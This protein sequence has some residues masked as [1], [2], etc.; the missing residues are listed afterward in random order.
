MVKDA[1]WC[2]YCNA[3][4]K[5]GQESCENCWA[6]L[7]WDSPAMGDQLCRECN[8]PVKSGRK[9]CKSCWAEL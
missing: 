7:K 6:E 2:S 9:K 1:K 5:F 8:A 4:I 3:P